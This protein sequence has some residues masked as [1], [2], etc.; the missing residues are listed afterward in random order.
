M[1]RYT[2][3]QAFADN[4]ANM[5]TVSYDQAA[6]A[7]AQ[8]TG[9]KSAKPEKV[10]NPY[11]S[12]AG[13]GSGEFHV[14]RH[15]R[16]REM[17]RWKQLNEEEREQLLDQEYAEKIGQNQTEEEKRT[18]QRRKKRQRQKEAKKRKKNLKL[19]GVVNQEVEEDFDQAEE[20]FS[21]TPISE[22]NKNETTEEENKEAKPCP[23][24]TFAN[25]GSFLE[26]MKKQM[27]EEKGQAVDGTKTDEKDEDERPAKRQAA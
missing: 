19:A 17:A 21:Y 10:S 14:Y 20:E 11:G 8:K 4:N 12:T 13:A 5:R 16:A 2:S 25:D 7:A 24:P 9:D 22:A 27:A 18:E 23:Q 6:G 26:Q 1:G 15:A 3:V